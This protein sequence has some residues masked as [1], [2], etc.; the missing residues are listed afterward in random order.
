MQR[1]LSMIAGSFDLDPNRVADILFEVLESAPTHGTL[2]HALPLIKAANLPHLL[3]LKLQLAANPPEAA[4][5]S[6]PTSTEGLARVAC[7][8]IARG[9]LTLPQIYPYLTPE[10]APLQQ[11]FKSGWTYV[12]EE[13]ARGG[14]SAVGAMDEWELMLDPS[15]LIEVGRSPPRNP[16]TS[17]A[18]LTW[19]PSPCRG[20]KRRWRRPAGPAAAGPSSSCCGCWSQRATTRRLPSSGRTSRRRG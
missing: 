6:Q 7:E 15:N 19:I 2:Y 3:G 14:S 8:M 1:R 16:G 10:D 18:V 5:D 12:Q 11:A 4:A 20:S 9:H 13:V 17:L